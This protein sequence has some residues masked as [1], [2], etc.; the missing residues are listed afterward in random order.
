[1]VFVQQY[2]Q[3]SFFQKDQIDKKNTDSFKQKHFL[4][5]KTYS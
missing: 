5:R 3:F 4:E 2:F 1:M